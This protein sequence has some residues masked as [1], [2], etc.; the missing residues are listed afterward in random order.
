M[1]KTVSMIAAAAFGAAAV[2]FIP[3]F[4]PVADAG[5]PP[6]VVKSDRLD[7]RPLG[8]ACSQ[9]AWPYYE[10][11]CVRDRMQPGGQARTVR[12]ISPDRVVAR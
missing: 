7:I 3:T 6:Q 1:Y 5:T 12:V 11:N 2:T 8:T 9:Q 4:A 10:A